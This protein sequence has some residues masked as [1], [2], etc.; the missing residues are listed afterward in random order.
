ME[1]VVV[2]LV[3]PT[4]SRPSSLTVAWPVAPPLPSTGTM[5]GTPSEAPLMVMDSVAVVVS[6]SPSVMV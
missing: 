6:P 2:S 3:L 4:V 5:V 1:P